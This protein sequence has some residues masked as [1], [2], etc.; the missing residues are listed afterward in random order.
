M[1]CKSKCVFLGLG[2]KVHCFSGKTFPTLEA[3]GQFFFFFNQFSGMKS[4]FTYHGLSTSIL[5]LQLRDHPY[6]TNFYKFS[7]S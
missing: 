2:K 7:G 4:E 1:H 3:G 6:Y 5:L